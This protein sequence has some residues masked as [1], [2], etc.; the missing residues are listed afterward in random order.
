[1]AFNA[2]VLNGI[3]VLVAVVEAGNFVRAAEVLGLTQSGVSRA[4]ARLEERVGVRLLQR[5]ARAVT[6]TDEGRR[7]YDRV[8]PLIAGIED[9]AG[10]AA[11]AST[12]PKGHLRVAIDPLVARVIMAPRVADFLAQ[13]PQLSLEIMVRD[14]LGDLISDGFD[15]AIRFGEPEPSALVARKL[16]ETRVLTY[17]S[18]AYLRKR[19]TPKHPREL[20]KHECILFRNP[21]TGRPYEWIFLSKNSKKPL[22]VKVSGRLLVNDS[23]TQLAVCSAGHGIAQPLEFE[24][25]GSA[26]NGLTQLFPSHAEERIP[27][28]VYYPSRALPPAKVRALIDFVVA[29]AR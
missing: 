13:N 18:T 9:A 19:G 27:L 15:A 24:I 6:L 10:D 4:I 21:S 28:Y 12:K 20:E 1:M 5:S 22:F 29:A 25:Q 2:R 11:D 14:R 26:A 16:L 23:A 8:S 7:F 3:G 17:A